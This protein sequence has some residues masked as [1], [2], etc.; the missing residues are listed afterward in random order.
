MKGCMGLNEGNGF[1]AWG[2]GF[3]SCEGCSYASDPDGCM[4]VR[5][6]ETLSLVDIKILEK[7]RKG[8]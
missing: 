8:E 1:K 7:I 3:R 5:I 2:T 6:K 4:K